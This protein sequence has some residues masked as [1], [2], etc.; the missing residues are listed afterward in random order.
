MTGSTFGARPGMSYLIFLSLMTIT[1]C[2]GY[3]AFKNEQTEHYIAVYGSGTV[4]RE[5]FDRVTQ[6]V[7]YVLDHMNSRVRKGLLNSN[8]KMLVVENE[9]E[10]ERSIEFFMSLLP[11]EAVYVSNEGRDESLPSSSDV[12]ISTTKLELM[13][14]CVYYSLLTDSSLSDLYEELVDAYDEAASSGLF[15]PGEAYIDGAVDEIHQGASDNNALKYGSYLNNLYWLY[16][17]DGTGGP[18]EFTITT[19]AELESQN[20]LGFGFVSAYFDL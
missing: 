15:V 17:G 20:P 8:A 13:Y 4:S 16:F 3:F 11:A 19:R 5:Q 9:E 10:L 6:D 14:L 7:E 12:G 18:G 1:A 2:D